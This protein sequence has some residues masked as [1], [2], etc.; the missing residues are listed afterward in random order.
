MKDQADLR[1][2][3][4]AKYRRNHRSWI[5]DPQLTTTFTLGTPTEQQAL[6]DPDAV[7]A[8]A[9]GWRR[10]RPPEGASLEWVVRN[11]PSWGRQ[12]LPARVRVVSPDAAAELAGQG[13]VWRRSQQIAAE[14]RSHWSS[15]AYLGDALPRLIDDVTALDDA[16]IR[17]LLAM[18]DWLVDH[19]ESGL[20]PRQVAVPGIDT[21]WLEMHRG[22]VERLVTAVTGQ[23]G[24]GLADE[25]QRFRIRVLDASLEGVT[26]SD[27]TADV[28][29]LN[30]L[31]VAPAGRP[32][33]R[34][35][36]HPGGAAADARG[37]GGA[38]PGVR[39]RSAGSGGL[40]PRGGDPLL[41]RS[42]HPRLQHPVALP[43]PPAADPIGADGL[44]R[45]GRVQRTR[46][47]RA[48]PGPRCHRAHLRR[49][50]SL[51]GDRAGPASPRAGT[52]PDGLGG[53]GAPLGTGDGVI[54]KT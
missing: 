13:Q 36:H 6:A 40:D 41:G 37:G 28:D 52:D 18:T 38:R 2:W 8:W 53:G 50:C 48:R 33:H 54:T 29:E 3:A 22:I 45:S 46:G 1:R 30:K 49:E 47:H 26:L 27:L 34:E 20:M 15:S 21:K 16:D 10:W 31:P 43:E 24:M 9:A 39:R 25:P 17:R 12:T 4:G 7:A 5:A 44:S 14:L 51:P 23:V 35:P 32:H 19:P 11:W 42:G